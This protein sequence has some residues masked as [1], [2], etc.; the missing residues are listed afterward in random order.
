MK[1]L[2]HPLNQEEKLLYLITFNLL[3]IV[4]YNQTNSNKDPDMTFLMY[5]LC[6]HKMF[7]VQGC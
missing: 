6:N 5:L 1:K 3:K 2:F 4:G 7:T